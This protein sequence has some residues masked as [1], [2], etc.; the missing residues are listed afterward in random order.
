MRKNT[1]MIAENRLK[2]VLMHDR[3]K[4]PENSVFAE[5]MKKLLS[6]AAA[7]L[8]ELDPDDTELSVKTHKRPGRGETVE[9]VFRATIV[10][11]R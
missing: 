10:K 9:L 3:A 6:G 2:N 7:S 4:N 5:E 8:A 11:L 1:G